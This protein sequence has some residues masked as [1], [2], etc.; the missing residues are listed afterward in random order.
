[1]IVVDSNILVHFFLSGEQ[2]SL[3]ERVHSR[4]PEWVAPI[5]WRSEFRNVCMK[6]NRF[7]NVPLPVLMK[8]MEEAEEAMRA[9][10]L[11]VQSNQVLVMA[12][13]YKLTA[14]DAEYASLATEL[15]CRLLTFD[16]AMI[17]KCPELISH[18]YEWLES[19]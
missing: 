13:R 9:Y 17:S 4:D 11:R 10:T 14:Y 12:N 2:R 7:G 5:L 16:K 8:G 3:L 1:M 18:P 6:M 19:I 15:D